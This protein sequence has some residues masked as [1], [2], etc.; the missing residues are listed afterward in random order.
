[1]LDVHHVAVQHGSCNSVS[2]LGI[3]TFT[4]NTLERKGADTFSSGTW[5]SILVREVASYETWLLTVRF[6]AVLFIP[7]ILKFNFNL[8]WDE[9]NKY[10]FSVTDM[11]VLSAN[12][13][14]FFNSTVEVYCVWLV[15]WFKLLLRA[16]FF[17]KLPRGEYWGKSYSVS[18]TDCLL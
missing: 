16:C 9:D 8:R 1:M 15:G 11:G 18:E 7:F 13:G 4:T 6:L 10:L 2:V 14:D 17:E 3:L 12:S 5:T